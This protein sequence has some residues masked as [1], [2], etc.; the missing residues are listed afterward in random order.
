MNTIRGYVDIMV[1]FSSLS[2]DA[3][4]DYLHNIPLVELK[5]LSGGIRA[6][7]SPTEY[8]YHWL[9]YIDNIL[10]RRISKERGDKL[11]NLGI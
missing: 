4:L 10:N 9:V 8:V 1:E 6:N 5:V 3:M 7:V 2:V 11:N